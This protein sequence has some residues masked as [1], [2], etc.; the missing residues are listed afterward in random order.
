MFSSDV[1]FLKA[2]S[3]IEV[4]DVGRVLY[5]SDVHLLKAL[6]PMDASD[7]RYH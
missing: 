2:S 4:S 1:Q 6:S 3:P 5:F 7:S